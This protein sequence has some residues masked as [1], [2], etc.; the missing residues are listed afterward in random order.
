MYRESNQGKRKID[1]LM[2]FVKSAKPHL[3]NDMQLHEF[4]I[5]PLS[6]FRKAF[7][8]YQEPKEILSFS[9]DGKHNIQFDNRELVT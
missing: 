8:I 2:Q 4:P 9:Y 6:R 7:P 3:K 1:D 5:H